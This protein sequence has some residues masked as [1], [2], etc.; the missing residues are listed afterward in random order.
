MRAFA[1]SPATRPGRTAGDDDRLVVDRVR[2]GDPDAA[3]TL[4]ER[5]FDRIYNYLFARLGA[6]AD[7][8]DL[9]IETMSHSLGRLDLYREQVL[10][11]SSWVYQNAYKVAVDHN[12]G[13]KRDELPVATPTTSDQA[14]L[15]LD[16]FSNED[17]RSAIRELADDQQQVLI[18]RFF[19]D[20]TAA[21]VGDIMGKTLGAV[22]ALQLRAL[23]SLDQV[24]QARMAA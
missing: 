12:L 13:R 20:L 11:F 8:E 14:E 15:R 2:R 10:A 19:Q 3:R 18:L 23:G 4:Y 22:Q 5:Y 16:R 1:G 21:Q 24:L 17:L 9:A 6:A 7:A